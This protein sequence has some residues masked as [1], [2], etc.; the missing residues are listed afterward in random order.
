M[1]VDDDEAFLNSLS[2]GLDDPS[3]GMK[4]YAAG[5]GRQ[6]LEV[7]RSRQDIE[8]LVT[9]LRMPEMD[10]FE[11]LASVKKDFPATR[12]I[13]TTA[14]VTPEV[15]E[16]L[17]ALGVRWIEKGAGLVELRRTIMRELGRR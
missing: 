15:E 5:N 13:A 12:A 10:G 14:C 4:V 1:L 9:D 16:Q 7:L 6:A 2:E 11:L 17:E 8:L 3:G